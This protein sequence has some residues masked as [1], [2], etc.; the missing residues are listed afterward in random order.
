[1]WDTLWH[2]YKYLVKVLHRTF[3]PIFALLENPGVKAGDRVVQQRKLLYLEKLFASL[4]LSGPRVKNQL[5][6]RVAE[7][8]AA[9]DDME[10]VTSS[11]QVHLKVLQALHNLLFFY[12]PA[13]FRVGY[14]VRCCTWDGRVAGTGV[15]AKEI[16]SECM[17]LLIHLLDDKQG[18]NEYVRTLAVALATWQPWMEKIPACCFVEES[19]EAML[20]R[21]GHRCDVHRTLHGLDNTF[22]LFVTLP[23]PSRKK[24][25]TRGML[26]QGLI[27]EF[28][29]R[30]RAL[31]FSGGH[32]CFAPSGKAKE[33]HSIVLNEFPLQFIFPDKFPASMP[34]GMLELVLRLCLR[35]LLGKVTLNVDVQKFLDDNVPLRS[36]QDMNHSSQVLEDQNKWLK[37][38][39]RVQAKPKP[40]PKRSP[41]PQPPRP[42]SLPKRLMPKPK[43]VLFHIIC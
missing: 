6:S 10:T 13:V 37:S 31:V 30:I 26:K 23:P 24:K 38:A 29:A 32:F 4:L 25:A 39:R 1:V 33:M 8:S 19:C 20:S 36:D 5:N 9:C 27:A 22:D 16:M 18:K 42:S 17:V 41:L 43:G 15:W 14:K 35:T 34:R 3:F 40:A 11:Q 7:L 12:L 21:M 2:C 28:A